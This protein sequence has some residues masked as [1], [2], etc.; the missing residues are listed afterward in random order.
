MTFR[1]FDSP[2]VDV[3]TQLLYALPKTSVSESNGDDQ[4]DNILNQIQPLLFFTSSD[5]EARAFFVRV[6][7]LKILK[8]RA[9]SIRGH[10]IP[11]IE[12]RGATVC[13]GCHLC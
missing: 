10:H 1:L 9:C 13:H 7:V 5:V 3:S 8:C 6:S 4:A 12:V 2:H 11:S